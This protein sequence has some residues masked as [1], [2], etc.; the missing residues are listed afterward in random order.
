M[1]NW[2]YHS[3][4]QTHK[5]LEVWQLGMDLMENTHRRTKAFPREEIYGLTSLLL[6]FHQIFLTCLSVGRSQDKKFSE[7]IHSIFLHSV[8]FIKRFRKTGIDFHLC[9][10]F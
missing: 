3:I 2:N 6:E 9:E 8:R 4:V 10:I 7:G 5:D 1:S